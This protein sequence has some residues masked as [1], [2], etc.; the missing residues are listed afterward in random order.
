M[1]RELS[2]IVVLGI[3][4]TGTGCQFSASASGEVNS[5]GADGSADASLSAASE[6]PAPAPEPAPERSIVLKEGKLDYQGVINFEYDKAALRND[7][8]TTRTLGEFENFLKQHGDVSIEIE[9]HT[10]S[11][12]SDDYNRDLSDRRAAS[13]RAWLIE[14]GIA[15]D[16]VT[17][18]GK[19]EDEPQ[20][21]EPP[22]CDDKRPK[23]TSPCEEIWAKN[24][25]VVFEVTQG[26]ETIAEPEKPPPPPPPPEPEPEPPVVAE[27]V[28]ACPW[29]WGGHGNALGPN[30]WLIVAGAV[31]PG[32][33]W[34]EPSLGLGLGFG[35]ITA[36]DPP[37]GTEGEGRH[38]VLNVPLRARIWF[39]DVHAPIADVGVG[40]S[41]YWISA[42]L[43][44][45]MGVSGEYSR[46]STV[47]YGHLGAGYGY[48]PNGAQAGFR[49]G[50]VV[51]ALLHFNDLEDSS[52]SS[53]A[54]FAPA[55]L[56]ELQRQL[57]HD[58]EGLNNVE[59]YGEVSFGW[60]F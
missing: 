59:P 3:L 33:C 21:P 17:A 32:I 35:G 25:R 45:S 56:A 10:D 5:A 58:S 13:V 47:V 27:P 40:L 15:E 39:M 57:N 42:D 2:S 18:V 19:G 26:A 4:L 14:R 37:P 43:E 1:G 20:V 23:D 6:E 9:G 51:G 22:E 12:G 54:G 34:L 7:P 50:I 11:R 29:L 8:D 53:D 55:E 46:D 49:L 28:E 44:D 38:W 60:L 48:R 24:R 41:R 36:E 31:Q 30:S 16:R 52:T